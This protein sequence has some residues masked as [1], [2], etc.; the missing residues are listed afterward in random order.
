[1]AGDIPDSRDREG[2]P[3][4]KPRWPQRALLGAVCVLVIAVF[5]WS[6][7]SGLLEVRAQS[8]ANT[9]YNLLAQGLGAG[10]LNL[11]LEVPPGFARLADPYDPGVNQNYRLRDGGPLHDLSYYHG[12]LYL[13]FGITPALALFW[14]CA[15]LTG[16]YLLHKDAVVIF[17]S[18]GFLA[19]ASLLWAMWRRYFAEIGLGIVAAG[20][21]ALGLAS[22][23][24]VILPRCDVY[25]VAV[26]CGYALLMLALG[27][28]WGALHQPQRRSWWLAGAS[29]A[30]GLA[31]GA[32]PSLIMSAVILLVPVV[33]AWRERQRL[34]VPLLAAAGPILLVG[35]GLALYNTLR[36]DNP[37]EFGRHYQLGA[38]RAETAR[39]FG[40][41]YLGFNAWIYFLA[42]ARWGAAFPFVHGISVP[43]GPAGYF[44]TEN[45]FGVLANIPLVWLALAAPLAG[46]GRFADARSALGGFL[47][48]VALMFGTC[49]LTLSLFFASCV[50]YQM[51]FVPTL[52]LLAVAGILGLER[53][54][55]G[56]GAAWRCAARCAWG[57][58]LAGS[59][60]FNLL[61]SAARQAQA[62]VDLANLLVGS[63][64]QVK[65][66]IAH[67]RQALKLQP[68]HAEAHNYL[69][70]ALQMQGDLAAA[71]A[72]LV[73]AVRL[74]PDLVRARLSLGQTLWAEGKAAEALA[75][76]QQVRRLQPDHAEVLTDLAWILATQPDAK[77][78]NGAEAVG[79]A[80]RAVELTKTND[81]AALDALAAAYAETGRFAEA[82]QKARQAADLAEAAG[83]KALATELRRRLALY[84]AGK[85][86]RPP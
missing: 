19:S 37:L 62:Q 73:E 24:P 68:T 10:Q 84:Q 85:P 59:V 6:A 71:E 25:E 43:P 30:C 33:Q 46:R 20:T 35:L 86:W 7:E 42:P 3:G 76:F 34:W 78:R 28:V 64:G 11:R 72:E 45:A 80:T 38:Y 16:H 22:L 41:R 27:A 58:L 77:L 56:R 79:L 67:Y 82:S 74:Q 51:E 17:C 65:Q 36:F 9:Y 47:L 23:I 29:L 48:A 52:V 18:V 54:L 2:I 49:A 31:V 39:D 63:R 81:A 83:Q 61:A 13:Y 53:A 60:A 1:V 44:G 69:G 14:P 5:A 26:S 55:A 50:R 21:L 4:A 66:A 15:A 8:A 57:V 75:E 32:R 12:K 70:A 40:F